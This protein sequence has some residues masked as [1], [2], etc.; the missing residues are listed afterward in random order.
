MAVF[1]A[2]L[3]TNGVYWKVIGKIRFFGILIIIL[4]YN[5]HPLNSHTVH[6]FTLMEHPSGHVS[7]LI[8]LKNFK[9][10]SLPIDLVWQG[11]WT[12]FA[13]YWNLILAILIA[14]YQIHDIYKI[15]FHIIYVIFLLNATIIFMSKFIIII[16]SS[17]VKTFILNLSWYIFSTK[18]HFPRS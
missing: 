13:E 6:I 5:L 4:G 15:H 9:L 12:H 2:N 8:K 17:M 10:I 3:K 11:G 14:Q 7:R 1:S 18:K 16:W